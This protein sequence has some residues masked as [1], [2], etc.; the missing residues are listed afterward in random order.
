M[1]PGR[2]VYYI[3]LGLVLEGAK[4]IKANS[5][6][7]LQGKSL[8]RILASDCQ[9]TMSVLHRVRDKAKKLRRHVT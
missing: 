8:G 5:L 2:A 9:T 1:G 7:H 3:G 4:A 6:L